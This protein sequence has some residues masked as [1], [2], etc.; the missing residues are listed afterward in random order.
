MIV[1]PHADARKAYDPFL[2]P[3]N[4]QQRQQQ[5]RG[6]VSNSGSPPDG[7]TM[8]ESAEGDLGRGPHALVVDPASA[9]PGRSLRR[10]WITVTLAGV[11]VL[12]VASIPL[13]DRPSPHRPPAAVGEQPSESGSRTPTYDPATDPTRFPVVHESGGDGIQ[14]GP[15]QAKIGTPYPFD[16]HVHCG[17][18][19][20]D[21]TGTWWIA[22]PV[23]PNYH[24]TSNYRGL[25]YVLGTMTLV[26][27]DE[28]RFDGPAEDLHITLRPLTTQL[29]PCD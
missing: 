4:Q 16:L 11:A 6:T 10:R 5:R 17:I 1:E 13:L 20:A 12:A 27:P 26:A 29:E 18:R 9:P 15:S 24:P 7:A 28:A 23:Q 21:F 8:D 22:D 19:Y 2:H 25:N 3:S 14:R